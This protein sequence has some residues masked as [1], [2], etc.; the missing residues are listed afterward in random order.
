MAAPFTKALDLDGTGEKGREWGRGENDCFAR[1]T[2]TRYGFSGMP[3]S[4][5]STF[6]S[7]MG[8]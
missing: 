1:A 4:K 8:I 3:E 2:D 6:N 7:E 5:K